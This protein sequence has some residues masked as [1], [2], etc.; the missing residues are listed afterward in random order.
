MKQTDVKG[1]LNSL[2][3]KNRYELQYDATAL[4]LENNNILTADV[5]DDFLQFYVIDGKDM[6]KETL[7]YSIGI[8]DF[9]DCNVDTFT[10]KILDKLSGLT[11]ATP[12]ADANAAPLS[13]YD[14][15]GTD[16]DTDRHAADVQ[17]GYG[18]YDEGG[19]FHYYP[20][21]WD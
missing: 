14:E 11:A 17:N 3:G 7:I 6:S 5:Y 19:T 1:W 20:N 18:Y 8:D 2:R 16:R 12:A 15:P 4:L 10:A 13:Q 21:Y 9:N